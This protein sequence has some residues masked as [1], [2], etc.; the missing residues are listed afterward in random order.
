MAVSE[1]H[2]Q[3]PLGGPAYI[4][5]K[6]YV[7][8]PKLKPMLTQEQIDVSLA[9]LEKLNQVPNTYLMGPVWAIASVY[10]SPSFTNAASMYKEVIRRVRAGEM[11]ED[12]HIP[13]KVVRGMQ[14]RMMYVNKMHY[15]EVYG[16]LEKLPEVTK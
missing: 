2:K 3:H 1:N 6:G 7:Q 12:R 9:H 14:V 4:D 5:E 16:V 11:F 15:I 13:G 8:L 10:E